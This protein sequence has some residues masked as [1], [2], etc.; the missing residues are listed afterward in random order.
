MTL[1][2]GNEITYRLPRNYL[3]LM[4]RKALS[5]NGLR[6]NR[7]KGLPRLPFSDGQL[8][9]AGRRAFAR[10]TGKSTDIHIVTMTHLVARHYAATLPPTSCTTTPV[11]P[12]QYLAQ[13]SIIFRRRS[14]MSPRR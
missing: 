1:Y 6:P 12:L 11:R 10:P 13:S 3:L 8:G 9:W 7:C 4:T 14:S 5:H 2:K